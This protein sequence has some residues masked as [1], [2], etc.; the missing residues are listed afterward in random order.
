MNLAVRRLLATPGF[1]AAVVITLA[2][3]IGANSLT[4][5]ALRGL[6]IQ[7]LPFKDAD[8]LVWIY[9]R[10]ADQNAQPGPVS[11][12]EVHALAERLTTIASFGVIGDKGLVV[13]GGGRFVQWHGLW[14]T[15][16][17]FDVLGVAPAVGRALGDGDM[18]GGGPPAMMLGY[19]RWAQDFGANPSIIG[20]VLEFSDN[21]RFTV[22]GILPPRLEFPIGR[23]PQ[24]GNG[25]GFTPGVQDFWVLGQNNPREYPGGTLLARLKPAASIATAGAE[26]RTLSAAL[27]LELPNRNDGRFFALVSLRDQLLGPLASAL[28]LLQGFA[29]L[30]LLIACSNLANLIMARAMSLELDAAIRIAL[31]ATRMRLTGA[32]LAESVVLCVTGSA[33]GLALAWGAQQWIRRIASTYPAIAERIEINSG[34]LLFT[35]ILCVLTAFGFALVPAAARSRLSLSML[36]G[37]NASRQT[38]RGSAAWRTP[39]VVAQVTLAIVLL[40]GASLIR[41]SLDRLLSV[42]MGYTSDRVVAA[43]VLLHVPGREVVAFYEKL[44]T[45]LRALP[46]VEAVGL[47]QSTPLTGMWTFTE[48][49]AVEGHNAA[50][51]SP[52]VSGSFVAFDYFGAMRIPILAGRTFT[53]SELL[54]GQRRAIILNDV[55]ARMLFPGA[56]PV[57]RNVLLSGRPR[58][59]VGVVKGTRDVRLEVPAEPQWYEPGL[60][61]GSQLMVRVSGEA[62]A[63]TSTLRR[64]LLAADSRL[65]VKSVEPLSRIL[66]EHLFERRLTS[67]L[68]AG[69]AAIAFVLA[70]TGLY[71]VMHVGF[72]QRKREF[73][74]RVALGAQRADLL[75]MV[76]FQGLFVAVLGI[77]AGIVMA[78][79][80]ADLLRSVLYDISPTDPATFAGVSV[81]VLVVSAATC[82]MPAWRAA[83]ADPLE[84]LRAD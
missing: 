20:S 36:L 84:T 27:G 24:S 7:P 69:F 45:T 40:T 75:R 49:L 76:L 12:P 42:D 28:P 29:A 52:Q 48:S 81:I 46:G 70:M 33:L 66:A 37:R 65:I 19:E 14:M 77:G 13:E 59:V 11:S 73:G 55:A 25:S 32:L 22:V 82:F 21:K 63:F 30:V 67:Q 47:I 83:T 74:L 23:P 17:L 54:P 62:D 68:L 38:T 78:V 57:G 5:G 50:R 44:Q 4:F 71:G 51:P 8:R 6:L 80:G 1:T 41:Q 56:N 39:L 31:G 18:G 3:G 53:D 26:A 61:G 34:V 43:D 16:G 60:V 10:T 79:T 15:P 58:E 9:A 72:V 64:E 35:S 2:L